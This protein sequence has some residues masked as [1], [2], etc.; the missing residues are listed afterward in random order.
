MTTDKESLCATCCFGISISG[1]ILQKAQIIDR[2]PSFEGEDELDDSD[3]ENKVDANNPF[4]LPPYLL[5]EDADES[6][7]NPPS[8]T[9][10][11]NPE[12]PKI[13]YIEHYSTMH[14]NQCYFPQLPNSTGKILELQDCIIE[15]CSRYRERI[16]V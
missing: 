11:E 14:T 4:G 5:E 9:G 10:K 7:S 3:E 12:E 16:E 13:L 8:Q 2:I 1:K 15:K 6:T